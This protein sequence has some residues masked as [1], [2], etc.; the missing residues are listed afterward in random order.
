M[1]L[2]LLME[3]ELIFHLFNACFGNYLWLFYKA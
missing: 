3:M 2:K 1:V